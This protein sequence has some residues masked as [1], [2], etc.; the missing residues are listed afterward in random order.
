ML[1]EFLAG[2]LVPAQRHQ[3]D[4]NTGRLYKLERIGLLRELSKANGSLLDL[5]YLTVYEQWPMT[6]CE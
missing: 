4:V 6:A 5:I 2:I 1:P 3:N